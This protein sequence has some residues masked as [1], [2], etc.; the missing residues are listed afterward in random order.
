MKPGKD[1]K[2][3]AG[4]GVLADI[5]GLLGASRVAEQP[6]PAVPAPETVER[7]AAELQSYKAKVKELTSQ[8]E[9]L[10]RAQ[11]APPSP[12]K[13]GDSTRLI[14]DIALLEERRDELRRLAGDLE[15]VLHLK[16]GDLLKRIARAHQ[17]VG[18]SGL[19]GEFRRA[20]GDLESAEY[21]ASFLSILLGR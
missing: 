19:G 11:Q 16:L 15:D 7:L 1:K 8:V 10:Q 21:F 14:E 12:V 3:V 6:Q 9:A 13:A 17:E 18:E 4:M 2:G 20:A 5:R